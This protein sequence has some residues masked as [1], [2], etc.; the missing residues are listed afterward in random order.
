MRYRESIL[1][2]TQEKLK[3]RVDKPAVSE[4]LESGVPLFLTQLSEILEHE[5]RGTPELAAETMEAAAARH[6]GELLTLGYSV[7]DVVHT[8][9]D[10]YQ[11][12]IELAAEQHAP[13]STD[14]LHTLRRCLDT[15]IAEA[16]T[17][18]GRSLLGLRDVVDST[19]ADIRM[20]ALP[21]QRE[22][23]AM[24]FFLGDLA[25]AAALQARNIPGSAC[26]FTIEIP[27]APAAG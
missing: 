8:Y 13:I 3:A 10:I 22:S 26:V 20:T 5:A 15:A 12:I 19:L 18:L 16:V 21:E 6:G 9:G 14:E 11:T 24:P 27:R 2:S 23:L 25:V 7:S 1:T 4:D 17:E